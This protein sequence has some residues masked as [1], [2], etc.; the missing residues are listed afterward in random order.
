MF[1]RIFH[2]KQVRVYDTTTLINLQTHHITLIYLL[3]YGI[4]RF[5]NYEL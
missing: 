4:F 1:I 5:K 3:I 2:C